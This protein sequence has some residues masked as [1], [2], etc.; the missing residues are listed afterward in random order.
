MIRLAPW[1]A[2]LRE[3]FTNLDQPAGEDDDRR[4]LAVLAFVRPGLDLNGPGRL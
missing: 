4:I 2:G 3:C 1:R